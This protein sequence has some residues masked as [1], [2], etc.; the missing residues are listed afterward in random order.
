M[1]NKTLVFSIALNGYQWMYKKELST[2]KSYANTYG[3]DYQSITR[4]SFS[5]LGV[6]CCWL[7]LTL[8][9]SALSAGY[10]TI[11]FIDADATVQENCP[12]LESI[13]IETKHLYM[14][15]GHSQRF[16]S[17]VLI[18]QNTPQIAEWLTRVIESRSQPIEAKNSV[19]WGENGHII[20]L[21][22][23]C[24]FIC[25]IEQKWNN[26]YD[27]QLNDFIQ[28]KNCGPLRNGIIENFSHRIIFF[29]S[30]RILKFINV[31][32]FL[33]NRL[34]PDNLLENEKNKIM[35]IYPE[36][37]STDVN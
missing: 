23:N 28:H 7:K 2:H 33:K 26:T 30:Y 18:A 15:K 36:F 21:S 3:Y 17:G 24:S 11:M 13:F 1:T 4:P 10:D 16:N 32:S 6:E 8:M 22:N 27:H 20:E 25:E 5:A 14:A 19:G 31:F 12:A 29:L 37:V 34:T 9:R 35:K